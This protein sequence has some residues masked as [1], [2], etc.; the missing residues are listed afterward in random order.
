[1]P[2]DHSESDAAEGPPLPDVKFF[3]RASEQ[4]GHSDRMMVTLF[5]GLIAGTVLLLLKEEVS[6]WVGGFLF[7]SLAMFVFGVGHTLLHMT[8]HHKM[9]L[10]LEALVNG[11]QHVPNMIEREEPTVRAYKRAQR[12]AQTAYSGQLLYLFLGVSIAAV[13]VIIRFWSYSWRGGV[14]LAVIAVIAL[15]G[16]IALRLWINPIR[17]HTK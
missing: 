7:V 15:G 13:G 17:A 1:M 11:T 16:A 14:V 5:S 12:Y 3:D 4:V 10:L 6:P 8:F 9:L 2:I